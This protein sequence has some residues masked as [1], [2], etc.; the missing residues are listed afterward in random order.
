MWWMG[1]EGGKLGGWV[2]GRDGVTRRTLA[3]C[4]ELQI[5]LG[6]RRRESRENINGAR[7]EVQSGETDGEV[8]LCHVYNKIH[9]RVQEDHMHTDTAPGDCS[10]NEHL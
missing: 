7:R 8:G 6:L 3:P 5:R 4:N 10:N 9:H 1:R 2:G